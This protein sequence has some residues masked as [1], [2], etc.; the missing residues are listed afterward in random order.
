VWGGRL[1]TYVCPERRSINPFHVLP[2]NFMAPSASLVMME[3][4][5]CLDE[6]V[7]LPV[8]WWITKFID[9][10][11]LPTPTVERVPEHVSAMSAA[12]AVPQSIDKLTTHGEN[13]VILQTPHT[14]PR[15]Y[16]RTSE[17]SSRTKIRR[18]RRR[19]GSV[20]R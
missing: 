19:R 3:T 10:G 1:Y 12:C 15:C 5:K 6:L 13:F 17:T 9:A 14:R 4:P 11:D 20:T 16:T 8:S 7:T 2:L 18:G